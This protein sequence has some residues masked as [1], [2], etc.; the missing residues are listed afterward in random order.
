[1]ADAARVALSAQR[2]EDYVRELRLRRPDGSAIDMT[3]WSAQLRLN[4]AAGLAGSP[5]LSL[6]AT[7]NGQGSICKV[8]SPSSGRVLLKLRQANIAALPGRAQDIARFAFNIL[9]TDS[10]GLVRAWI[11]GDLTVE[12]GV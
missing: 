1:M 6:N 12:P 4:T 8:S 2:N 5:L 11:R 10:A 9:L 3:G 7:P